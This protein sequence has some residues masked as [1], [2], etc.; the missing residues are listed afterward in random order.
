MLSPE[1]CE[2]HSVPCTFTFDSEV[3]MIS[4]IGSFQVPSWPS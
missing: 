2:E 1:I 4:D 3:N